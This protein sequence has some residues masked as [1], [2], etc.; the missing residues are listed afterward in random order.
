[1]VYVLVVRVYAILHGEEK[2]GLVENSFLSQLR[3]QQ[4]QM[5]IQESLK[6]LPRGV[7][8]L[9]SMTAYI[10]YSWLRCQTIVPWLNGDRTLDAHTRFR[11]LLRVLMNELILHYQRGVTIPKS[12]IFRTVEEAGSI[13][14]LSGTLEMEMVM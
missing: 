10:T 12:L 7:A 8:M 1:M 4:R 5:D 3:A 6:T 14:G 13:Y 11:L 2:M 9:F